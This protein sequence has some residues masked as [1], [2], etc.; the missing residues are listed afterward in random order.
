MKQLLLFFLLV[1]TISFGQRNMKDSVIGTPLLGIQYGINKT[2]GDLKTHHLMFNHIG[3]YA[4][5]KTSRNWTFGLDANFMFGNKVVADGLF[6]NLIDSK[7]NISD[8]NGDIAS[9]LVLSR[10]MY[11]DVVVGKLFPVLSPNLNS[12]IYTSFGVGWLV[13]KLRIETRDQVVPLLELDYRKGY[14][15]LTS[16]LNTEQF[17]GYHY[18][19]DQGFLN[20][21]GGFYFQQGY[22]FNRRTI[23]FDQPD[24][25]VSKDMK[26]DLQY[27]LRVGWLIPVYK[28]QPKEYYYN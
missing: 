28:R 19:A 13:H 24:T 8:V 10:G 5:Y 3:F 22:T 12:G 4:G 6:A 17:V 2:D 23:N 26:L 18:M 21:Y 20:F 15:R 9:V 25:P 1:S 16:G 27:G 11:A 7:G 14:D